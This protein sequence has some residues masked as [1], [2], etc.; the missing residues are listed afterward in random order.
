MLQTAGV[1][2]TPVVTGAPASEIVRMI[3]GTPYMAIVP[4]RIAQRATGHGISVVETRLRPVTV[5][6][7]AHW[8]PA[9][10]DDAA[11]VWLLG[12]L[13]RVAERVEFPPDP[14]P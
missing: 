11:L 8:H 5:V 1:A 6:E 13:R 4:E 3:R 10:S 9:R 2:P 14:E 12:V 7:A